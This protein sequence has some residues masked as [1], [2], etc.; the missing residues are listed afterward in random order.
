MGIDVELIR[1]EFK[2]DVFN[3][4]VCKQL[5]ENPVEMF[6]CEHTFCK[7]CLPDGINSCPECRTQFCP[8]HDVR[9]PCL[10]MKKTLAEIKLMCG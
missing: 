4:A 3:C 9:P 6:S 1:G 5:L 2:N 7:A 8:D 10:F